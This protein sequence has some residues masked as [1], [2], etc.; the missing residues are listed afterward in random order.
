M[1]EEIIIRNH[2][3]V[4]FR[5]IIGAA[6]ICCAFISGCATTVPTMTLA[7]TAAT[8]V[9]L[10]GEMSSFVSSGPL[11]DQRAKQ[12]AAELSIMIKQAPRN[13][14]YSAILISDQERAAEIVREA[15]KQ[16]LPDSLKGVRLIYVGKPGDEQVLRALAVKAGA[17]F[18]FKTH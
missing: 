2:G 17:E 13:G 16:Q 8:A 7:R 3:L 10:N 18:Y 15:L 6:A 4:T 12:T 5:V 14:E 9:K 1:G 11:D